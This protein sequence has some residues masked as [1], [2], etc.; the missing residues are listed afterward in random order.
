MLN[1]DLGLALLALGVISVVGVAAAI[2]LG[3]LVV[4][5]TVVGRAGARSREDRRGDDL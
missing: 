3:I 5:F 4:G 2:L 1:G